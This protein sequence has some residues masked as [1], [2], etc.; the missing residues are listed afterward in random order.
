LMGAVYLDRGADA[1]RALAAEVVR[2]PLARLAAGQAPGRDPKS[3]LQE[4]VQAGGGASPRYRVV[5]SE[6]PDHQRLFIVVVEA[7]GRVLG[8]GRGRSKKL[9]EQA[10]ARAAIDASAAEN[11]AASSG[12]RAAPSSIVPSTLASPAGVAAGHAPDNAQ[13]KER[14]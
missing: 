13:R 1:A 10:A 2:E 11:D 14:S 12:P 9:A 5:G 3:E 7:F 8:E 4:R 6:G